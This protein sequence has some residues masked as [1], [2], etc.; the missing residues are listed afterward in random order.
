[1]FRLLKDFN[2]NGIS[3]SKG[4]Y[5]KEQLINLYG[6]EDAFNFCLTCTSLK[7]VLEEI[8]D[9]ESDTLIKNNKADLEGFSKKDSPNEATQKVITEP[10]VIT[11]AAVI[12]EAG[13]VAEVAEVA[14]AAEAKE[15]TKEEIRKI[16]DERG[17]NYHHLN[18]IDKLK[19]LLKS[20]E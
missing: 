3:L 20:S 14:E 8:N 15:L 13:E 6:T 4:E 11:E 10:G 9:K 19:E 12:T 18:G 5:S 16:L 7:Y 1:M 17:V 2:E